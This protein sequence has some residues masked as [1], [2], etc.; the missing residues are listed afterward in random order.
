MSTVREQW[1]L[2]CPACK[3]DEYLQVQ[4]TVMADLSVEGSDPC[5]DQEWDDDSFIRCRSCSHTG[6][7]KSFS[8]KEDE[9]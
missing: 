2:A 5:S 8:I 7:V 1:G 9:P 6:T 3:S 4:V